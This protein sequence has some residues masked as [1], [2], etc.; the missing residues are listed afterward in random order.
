[1]Q[2]YRPAMTHLPAAGANFPDVCVFADGTTIP[3][4]ACIILCTGYEFRF[5]SFH[6]WKRRDGS[7]VQHL[8]RQLVYIP[9]PTLTF[10][11]LPVRVALFPLMSTARRCGAVHRAREATI[12]GSKWKRRSGRSAS[13]A[14]CHA[15]GGSRGG[16]LQYAGSQYA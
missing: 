3:T 10:I 9:D 7:Y 16:I 11:G 1:M 2:H 4:P 15:F 8:F 5:P 13:V 12:A 6:R 14:P